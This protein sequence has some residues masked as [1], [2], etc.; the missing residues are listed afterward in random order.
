MVR[1][2]YARFFPLMDS[3]LA[4]LAPDLLGLIGRPASVL[5]QLGHQCCD[6][7]ALGA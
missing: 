6:A 5:Q 2:G 7:A 4:V 1:N 3:I